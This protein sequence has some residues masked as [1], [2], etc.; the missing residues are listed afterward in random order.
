MAL[1][2]STTIIV[3]YTSAI[4]LTLA[5]YG[6]QL[7]SFSTEAGEA[8]ALWNILTPLCLDDLTHTILTIARAEIGLTELPGVL[9]VTDADWLV[10]NHLTGSLVTIYAFT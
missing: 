9:G 3:V 6:I 7:A 2:F 4:I 5:I 8:E 1:K 10:L